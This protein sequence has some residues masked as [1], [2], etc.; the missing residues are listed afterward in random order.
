MNWL[1]KQIENGFADLRGLSI[2]AHVPVKDQM[3]NEL[4]TEALQGGT[5]PRSSS[6]PDL[7]SLVKFV[8]KAEV[9]AKEGALVLDIEIA[10]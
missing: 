8:R 7:R 10:V 2:S 9:H 5:T 4:L 6:G 3:L 1:D